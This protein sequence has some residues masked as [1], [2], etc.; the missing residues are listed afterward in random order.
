MYV[1]SVERK[2]LPNDIGWKHKLLS[3]MCDVHNKYVQLLL[4]SA[5]RAAEL[6]VNMI[7]SNI[8]MNIGEMA[9]VTSGLNLIN[10]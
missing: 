6:R 5:Y 7:N 1:W 4:L 8:E 10:R 2:L 9:F 3:F